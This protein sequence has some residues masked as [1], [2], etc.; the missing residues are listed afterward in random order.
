M[1]RDRH[2]FRQ[3]GVTGRDATRLSLD[4]NQA[5]AATADG[6]NPI[7]MAECRDGD[8]GRTTCVQHGDAV[9]EFVLFPVYRCLHRFWLTENHVPYACP[10]IIG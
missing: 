4:V 10:R 8:A 6:L 5:Q 7:V 2:P 3:R 9:F 1:C